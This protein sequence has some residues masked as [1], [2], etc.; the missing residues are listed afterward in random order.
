MRRTSLCLA[1]VVLAAWAPARPALAEN[2]APDFQVS[3]LPPPEA[4]KPQGVSLYD[5][6][7][8]ADVSPLGTTLSTVA[9]EDLFD[10]ASS[11]LRASNGRP[12]NTGEAAFW[13]KHAI[14]SAPDESG[15]RRAWALMRL[16]ALIYASGPAGHAAARP[17]WELAAAWNNADAL[18]DLGELA[19]HGDD[20][21]K[22]DQKKARLWYERAQKAGCG[23]AD[24]ALAR[25]PK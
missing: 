8:T 25:L 16:G 5:V 9:A 11:F 2:T 7:T 17:L 24:D 14:S 19:E 20:V 23:K 4:P 10:K 15:Q 6:F 1:L 21:S 18:C 12:A 22:P 3:D 13:L